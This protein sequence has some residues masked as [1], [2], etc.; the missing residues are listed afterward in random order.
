MA[1]ILWALNII[2]VNVALIV[3]II[4]AI[5]ISNAFHFDLFNK[6]IQNFDYFL[7]FFGI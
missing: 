5:L 3:E 7:Y 2:R 6:N 1:I 4:L